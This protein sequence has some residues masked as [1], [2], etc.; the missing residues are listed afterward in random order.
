MS[1]ALRETWR[2]R[3]GRTL[4][5]ASYEAAGGLHGAVART[6]ESAFVTQEERLRHLPDGPE[7]PVC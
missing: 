2:R 3:R 1:H 5:L 6:A 7:D 4:T